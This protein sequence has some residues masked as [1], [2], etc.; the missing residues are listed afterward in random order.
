MDIIWFRRPA[1]DG[2]GTTSDI[3]DGG[4]VV[5]ADT[6]AVGGAG[7]KVALQA[8]DYNEIDSTGTLADNHVNVIT[9]AAGFASVEAFLDAID[10]SGTAGDNESVILG[11]FNS[12]TSQ[13]EVHYVSDTGTSAADHAD[14][15]SVELI[16]FTDVVA[17]DIADTFSD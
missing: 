14:E 6:D 4:A 13:F 9:D 12:T 7:T 3:F 16:S 10:T 15:V 2:S 8:T 1:N 17:A 11:F 5:L